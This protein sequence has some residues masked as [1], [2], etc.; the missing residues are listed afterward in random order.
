[1]NVS[2]WPNLAPTWPNRAPIGNKGSRCPQNRT[3]SMP[4]PGPNPTPT[5]SQPG[6]NQ[7]LN[8]KPF[9]KRTRMDHV[10]QFSSYDIIPTCVYNGRA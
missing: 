3:P 5:R 6:P 8:Y 4:Q 7:S 2:F 9:S 10:I 1:M